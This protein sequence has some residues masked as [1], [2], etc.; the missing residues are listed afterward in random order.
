MRKTVLLVLAAALVALPATAPSAGETRAAKKKGAVHEVI[1][2]GGPIAV[3]WNFDPDDLDIAK[4]DR[5]A[6][7]NPTSTTHHVTFY[8][9]PVEDSLH[10]PAGGASVKRFKKPGEYFYRCDINTHSYLVG[11]EC[12]GMC[13]RF[14]VE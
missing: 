5:I 12:V 11:G 8:D 9:S 10:V 13:G 4:K 1:M 3:L 2:G 14:T 6:W 7:S